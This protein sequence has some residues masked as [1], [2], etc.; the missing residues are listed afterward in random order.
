MGNLPK[1]AIM[2]ANLGDEETSHVFIMTWNPD[3]FEISE[4]DLAEY[5]ELT[6][7]DEPFEKSN[8]AT[9]SRNSGVETGDI[10]YLFQQGQKGRGL[11]AKGVIQSEVYQDEHWDD[12]DSVTNFVDVV[13][14]V[15]LS[16]SNR[17]PIEDVMAVTP[18]THWNQMQGSGVQLQPSDAGAL[19]TL[20][21]QWVAR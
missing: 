5:V 9:G 19:L 10:A 2:S 16:A 12:E 4:S 8:W 6:K 14:S 21:D 3:K 7:S 17:L 13:W 18:N 20:W 15:W 11:I 1:G